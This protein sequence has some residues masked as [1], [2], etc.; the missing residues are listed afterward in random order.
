MKLAATMSESLTFLPTAVPG[1]MTVVISIKVRV[2]TMRRRTQDDRMVTSWKREMIVISN[3]G[4][5]LGHFL[6]WWTTN[7]TFLEVEYGIRIFNQL[8][9]TEML[10]IHTEFV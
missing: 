7:K 1:I 10:K 8:S 4:P 2:K 9:N 6:Q 3:S 5:V